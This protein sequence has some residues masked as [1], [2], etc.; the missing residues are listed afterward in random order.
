MT[1]SQGFHS[2]HTHREETQ[3]KS[4]K[5]GE[6]HAWSRYILPHMCEPPN[7]AD[8]RFQF[9]SQASDGSLKM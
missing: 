5:K 9:T 7:M 3:E 2:E 4:T 1:S 8:A 6:K